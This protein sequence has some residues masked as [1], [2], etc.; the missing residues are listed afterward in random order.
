MKTQQI[1]TFHSMPA[2]YAAL[3]RRHLPRPIHDKVGYQNALEIIEAF[4]GFEPLMNQDQHDYFDMLCKLI[5]EYEE[6]H[7]L[8]NQPLPLL[9]H[10]LNE[11]GMT[12]ADLSRVLGTS[13]TVGPMILRQ[14]RSITAAHARVLGAH[15]GLPAGAFIA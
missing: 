12:G 15:F 3:C 9:R 10:L 2:A 5:A 1:H 8:K 4:A 14:Q 13:R 7:I 11:H 6:H